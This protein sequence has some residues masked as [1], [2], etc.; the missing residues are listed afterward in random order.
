MLIV[1]VF[2]PYFTGGLFWYRSVTLA[3][4]NRYRD[5]CPFLLSRGTFK[6]KGFW[7]SE[8]M[9]G[10]GTAEAVVFVRVYIFSTFN[11]GKL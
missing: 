10:G 6:G 7:G 3:P 4:S 11:G 5:D 8:E 9:K 1:Q 2:F